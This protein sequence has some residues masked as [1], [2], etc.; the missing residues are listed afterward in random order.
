[1][2]RISLRLAECVEDTVPLDP[3]ER[4]DQASDLADWLTAHGLPG[5]LASGLIDCR[6]T[7]EE[8]A[9]IISQVRPELLALGLRIAVLDHEILCLTREMEE[10]SHRIS[11]L[12]KA[13]K[14]YSYMDQSQMSEVDVA[15]GIDV[16]LR[17]FQHKLKQG[18]QVERKYAPDLPSICANGSA[19]NQVWT[20]LI[21]NS[22]DALEGLP[23]GQQRIITIRTCAERDG[24]LVEIGDNGPGI[25]GE[26]RDRIFEPFFTTKSVGDGSGLGLD[27]VQRI[28]RTHKGAI[29]VDSS[30]GRTVFQIRLPL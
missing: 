2:Y 28:I 27:I 26:V 29:R 10:A 7:V 24:I 6:I 17:M 13:V 30:P 25:P 21:D 3:L 1:M 14:S 23:D 4:A 16:T 5:E 11:E 18:I 9:A 12:V 15:Q 22:I 19:L 8:I 20:N